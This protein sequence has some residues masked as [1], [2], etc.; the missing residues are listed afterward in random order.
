MRMDNRMDTRR[1]RDGS[2]DVESYAIRAKR[3][4]AQALAQFF[5]AIQHRLLIALRKLYRRVNALIRDRR[6]G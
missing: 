2:I 1:H 4:R 6:V 3:L 5:H